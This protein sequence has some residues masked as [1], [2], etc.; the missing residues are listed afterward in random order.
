MTSNENPLL[1]LLQDRYGERWS[2]RR[3]ESLWIA[4]VR[5]PDADHAPT[6]VEPD[7]EEF[8]RQLE[9]PPPGA[10]RSLLSAGWFRARA[11]V[12]GDGRYRF[13]DR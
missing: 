13:D 4:T 5:R 6:L 12:F 9:D 8:V 3:T 10:G 11:R 2:I 7:I 1:R